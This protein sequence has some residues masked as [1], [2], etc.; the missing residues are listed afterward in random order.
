V[1][2][3]GRLLTVQGAADYLGMSRVSLASRGWRIKNRL[4]AIKLGRAVRF[5]R[6]MLDRWIEQHREHLPALCTAE[7][8]ENWRT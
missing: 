3:T 1:K 4:P 6:Q 8:G 2:P 5:D 7:D